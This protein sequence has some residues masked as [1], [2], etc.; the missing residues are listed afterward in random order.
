M[1][2]KWQIGRASNPRPASPSSRGPRE[3]TAQLK[4]LYAVANDTDVK[5]SAEISIRSNGEHLIRADA[6]RRISSISRVYAEFRSELVSPVLIV[7]ARASERP[8]SYISRRTYIP[9][10]S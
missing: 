2:A 10:T 5:P 3:N 7:S 6:V 1:N 8:E 9:A 4:T